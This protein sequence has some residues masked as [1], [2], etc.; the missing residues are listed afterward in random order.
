MKPEIRNNYILSKIR[1]NRLEQTNIFM[2]MEEVEALIVASTDSIQNRG[3][4]RFLTNY[5]TIYGLSLAFKRINED[6]FLIVPAGSFQAG[7]AQRTVWTEKIQAVQDFGSAIEKL[8]AELKSDIKGVGFVGLENIPG[9]FLTKITSSFPW[10][11]FVDLNSAYRLMKAV[12]SEPEIEMARNSV[13]L[14]DNVFINLVKSTNVGTPE[15]EIF[16]KASYDVNIGGAEDCFF[17]GSS[18]P[19]TVISFPSERLLSKGDL[20]RFS[21]EPASRGGFWTQTIRTISVGKP[22]KETQATFDLCKEA[23]VQASRA[24]KPGKTGGEIANTMINVLKQ[25]DDGEIGPLGHGMGLDLTEPPY[26]L[27]QD[28]T[29][30]KP[31][32][33]IAIHPSFKWKGIDIWLGDTYLATESGAE[34]LSNYPNELH[35]L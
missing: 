27:P 3:N 8:L 9:S 21:I 16:A 20:I 10:I 23:I 33:V 18:D 28:E 25:V 14:A 35:I 7:W 12:K 24:I 1:E 11:N 32:M 17:L 30:I 4:V 2:E 26:I 5:S 19:Q 31:G 22:S 34:N 6:P 13:S 15:K 29:I